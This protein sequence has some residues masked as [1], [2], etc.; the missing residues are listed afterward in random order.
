MST[1]AEIPPTMKIAPS[2][3]TPR[4]TPT[5][6]HDTRQPYSWL[7]PEERPEV[8]VIIPQAWLVPNMALDAVRALQRSDTSSDLDQ[9]NLRLAGVEVLVARN[10]VQDEFWPRIQDAIQRGYA[11]EKTYTFLRARGDRRRLRRAK[12]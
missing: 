11:A 1:C 5:A 4:K 10:W 9:G 7:V 12:T 6:V 3:W 8:E 2:T